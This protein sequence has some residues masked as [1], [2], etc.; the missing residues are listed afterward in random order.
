MTTGGTKMY[1]NTTVVTVELRMFIH[2][3]I[4][5]PNAHLKTNASGTPTHEKKV[6]RS[7]A[8]LSVASSNANGLGLVPKLPDWERM[9]IRSDHLA[10]KWHSTVV[11]NV[12][13]PRITLRS[14]QGYSKSH[15]MVIFGELDCT[16]CLLF[17]IDTTLLD[18]LSQYSRCM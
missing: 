3:D 15:L 11:P 18:T 17:L 10:A 9:Q 6:T 14:T 8:H 2:V 4:C 16:N 1:G 7:S 5:F 12:G 13:Q